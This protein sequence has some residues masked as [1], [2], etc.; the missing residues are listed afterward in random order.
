M[1]VYLIHG[2]IFKNKK[3]KKNGAILRQKQR[4]ISMDF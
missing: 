4:R 3:I 2:E 1:K